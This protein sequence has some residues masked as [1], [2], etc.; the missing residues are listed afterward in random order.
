MPKVGRWVRAAQLVLHEE[1]TRGVAR[2][3]IRR[4]YLRQSYFVYRRDLTAQESIPFPEGLTE[5]RQAT[6]AERY[7]LIH[8]R[9]DF[10]AASYW[11]TID[12]DCDCYVGLD[13]YRIVAVHWLSTTREPNEL[14]QLEP[15]DFIIGPCVTVPT[16]RGRG[17]YPAMIRAVCEER[18]LRGEKRAYMVVSTDNQSS[19][20]GIEKAGFDNAGR[21]DL[22][23]IAGVRHIERC[24][25]RIAS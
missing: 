10:G 22:T 25:D 6:R 15:G 21:S 19:I 5:V 20:R 7:A 8:A 17:L 14:V 23:R 11:G 13:G 16:H 3:A 9:E 18:R 24:D 12:P 1:G 4:L 2:Y